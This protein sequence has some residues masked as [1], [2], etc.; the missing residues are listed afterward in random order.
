[1]VRRVLSFSILALVGLAG[2]HAGRNSETRASA[3][4]GVTVY[5]VRGKVVST[6]PADGIVVLDGDAIPGF[7]G[8]MTMPYQLKDP[9]IASELH[10]GDTI[11]ADVLVSK[12]SAQTVLL[13]DVDVIA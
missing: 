9:G 7:M 8:A 4:A 13:D 6:D 2:C 1:M 3:N 12:S 11:T 5:H 10:P